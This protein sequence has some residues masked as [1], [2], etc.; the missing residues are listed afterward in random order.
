L[1]GGESS[2]EQIMRIPFTREKD[3]GKGLAFVGIGLGL[4]VGT[5]LLVRAWRR[6]LGD[7][8]R[9]AITIG[10]SRDDVYGFWRKLELLPKFMH[11]IESVEDRGDGISHWKVKTLGGVS[12]EYDAEIIEDVP[13]HRIRWRSLPS[14]TVANCGTVEFLDAPGD[15]GCEVI[16]EMQVAAPLGKTIASH[17]AAADLRRLKQILELGEILQS[18]ASIHEA[19]HPAQPEG[20]LP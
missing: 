1:L 10:R 17:E 12:I 4:T 11:W 18:D 19:P 6:K 13:G 14:A 3:V 5:V 16:V 9:R 7:P 20:E 15:R 8:V 2:K